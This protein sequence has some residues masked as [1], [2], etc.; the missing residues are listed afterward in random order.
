V[1]YRL[2]LQEEKVQFLQELTERRSMCAGP[3]LLIGDFNMI[4]RASEKNNKNLDRGSMS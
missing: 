1:V 4:L 2:Q 3:W